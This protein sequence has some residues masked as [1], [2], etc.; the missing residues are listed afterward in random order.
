MM[1]AARSP[2][3]A[4]ERM[5]TERIDLLITD[6]RL[7]TQSGVTFVIRTKM[8]MPDLPV[9]IITGYPDTLTE[10]DAKVYGADYFF[11]KPLELQKVREAVRTCLH[12]VDDETT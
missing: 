7:K 1:I 2:D 9:I 5:K 11:L 6:I 3:N 8:D 10:R 4:L 12:L